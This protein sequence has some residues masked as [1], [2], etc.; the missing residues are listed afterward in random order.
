MTGTPLLVVAALGPLL[1]TGR[2]AAQQTPPAP[3]EVTRLTTI[4]CDACGDARE[5]G[6][7]SDLAVGIDGTILVAGQDAPVVR[8]FSRDGTLLK[9]MGR[10]GSGPGEFRFPMRASFGPGGS[11]HVLDMTLRRVSH[12]APDGTEARAVPLGAFPGAVASR[13]ETGEL[14]VLTDDFR[15]TLTLLRF[16]AG[17]SEP[18]IV[19]K[20]AKPRPTDGHLTFPVV[21]AAA[22][23]E[24]ALG[25]VGEAY[26]ITRLSASGES[27]GEIVREIPQVRRTPEEI[28]ELTRR[29]E[30]ARARVQ[31]EL[32]RG[33]RGG[34]GGAAP[35]IGTG[36]DTF[37]PHFGIDALRYD[38]SGR[39]WVLTMRG[40][41]NEA[42][43]D[44]FAPSGAF[45]GSLVVPSN[46]RVYALG[47]G[48]L[49]T[50][51]E[52]ADGVPVVELWRVT[53]K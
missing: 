10:T 20:I 6:R 16:P 9:Q 45:L 26:R 32:G 48:Y 27:V 13:G 11:I 49:V 22:N 7:I 23:G 51:G 50:H 52:N 15:G 47:G 21:A 39:L 3:V 5:L 36:D 29:R 46:V 14:V 40:K 25:H 33:G 35:S 28:E 19:S 18:T 34:R 53:A 37:K 8:L 30:S 42:V 2:L 44:L 41:E 24:I 17:A 31:A 1:I 12:L 4:G 43:F 38:A